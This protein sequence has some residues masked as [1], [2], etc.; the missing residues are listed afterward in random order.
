MYKGKTFDLWEVENNNNLII[1]LLLHYNSTIVRFNIKKFIKLKKEIL[2]L[3]KNNDYKGEVI[4][5]NYDKKQ[6]T[7]NFLIN[8]LELKLP[9][10]EFE[11]FKKKDKYDANTDKKS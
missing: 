4:K 6:V 1:N 9:I 11:H 8:N 5:I 2:K 7:L 3:N 10:K